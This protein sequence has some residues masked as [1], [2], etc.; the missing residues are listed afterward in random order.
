[1]FWGKAQPSGAIVTC[2]PI[3]WHGLDVAAAFLALLEIWPDDAVALSD[4]FDGEWEEVRRALASLIALHDIGKFAPAF[5]AKVPEHV[6]AELRPDLQNLSINHGATGL[7]YGEHPVLLKP[8]MDRILAN[9]H[10]DDR[11][12]ILQPVFGHHGRPLDEERFNSAR[13]GRSDGSFVGAARQFMADV[14]DLFGQPVLPAVRRRAGPA[15]SWRLAG[16]IAMSD[17]I[18]SSQAHFP[19]TTPEMSM[20]DYW[21]LAQSRAAQAID[22]TGLKGAAVSIEDA[23]SAVTKGQFPLTQAQKWSASVPLDSNP[24]L[25]IIEDMMGSG[26]TEAALILAHRLMQAGRAGGLYVALPTMATANALYRRMAAIYRRFFDKTS[27]PS[28]ILAHGASGLDD[29]FRSSIGI[30]EFAGETLP[31][32]QNDEEETSTAACTRWLADDRRKTFLADVGVGTID[33]ALLA[34]LPVKHCAVRQM[35]L[36]RRVLIIDEAHAYD[37]YMQKEIET[38][39]GHQAAM[40]A[41]VIILSATLPSVIRNRLTRAWASARKAPVPTMAMASYPLAT[42]MSDTGSTEQPLAAR[43]DLERGMAILRL[44]EHDAADRLV[45]EAAGQGAAVARL[46]N[47]VDDAIAAYERLQAQ[48]V[49]VH[50]F[51]A[52]FAMADRI[53]IEQ[54]AMARFGKTS[55]SEA[56]RGHVLV[57]T[58]VIEQSLDVDFDLMVTDLA[59]VDLL[60]QRA[61]RVWRHTGRQGRGWN[62]PML[63]VVSPEAVADAGA[64]WYARLFPHAQWVYRDHAKLWRTAH[65]LFAKPSIRLPDDMRDLVEQVYDDAMEDIPA[66]LVESLI[67]VEGNAIASRGHAGGN[68]LKFHEGYT[69]QGGLWSSDTITPT[70]ESQPRT[71]LRLSIL[72]NGKLVPYAHDPDPR[73]AWA[74]SEIS[75]ATRRVK[76]RGSYDPRI[77]AQA[78]ALEAQ[79]EREGSRAVCLPLVETS[80]SFSFVAN[81]PHGKSVSGMYSSVTGLLLQD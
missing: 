43:A 10:E 58:Q 4:A 81:D 19:Y 69:P 13:D 52:R 48:G 15:L 49:T 36:R 54:S 27:K 3:A 59:P 22:Q 47:T 1:M 73:R 26:K 42:L 38:L 6:P 67:K 63:A 29:Q 50:L 61:G 45:I 56:R 25:F 9:L 37:S 55:T 65:F 79:W 21:C 16:L 35:G 41:P 30:E 74:L 51:H 68:V 62:E 7:A 17:W 71:T 39:I 75:V 31:S 11:S 78:M 60:L 77:A 2:H 23:V 8:L 64:D 18:G 14:L 12:V 40:N 46:C 53:A 44:P 34:I 33:Q 24:G 70:R 80:Q 72:Q 5:Q 28:L 76:S 66:A 57:A 32:F 20:A